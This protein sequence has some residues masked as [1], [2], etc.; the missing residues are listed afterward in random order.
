[1]E[2]VDF[3]VDAVPVAQS[4]SKVALQADRGKGDVAPVKHICEVDAQLAPEELLSG[5]LFS[6]DK[7]LDF[8]SSDQRIK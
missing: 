1:M 6:L 5:S 7:A 4:P 3:R 2:H 8:F